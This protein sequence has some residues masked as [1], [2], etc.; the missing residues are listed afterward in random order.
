MLAAC[1]APTTAVAVP[2]T[3]APVRPQVVGLTPSTCRSAGTRFGASV[4]AA[5]AII[6][7]GLGGCSAAPPS[8]LAP[9]G[10][11]AARVAALFWAMAAGAVT[12]WAGV[13]GL[14]VYAARARPVSADVQPHRLIVIGGVLLPGVLLAALLAYGLRLMPAPAVAPGTLRVVV[15]GERWWWR[16]R[17]ERPGAAPVELANEL[18]LPAGVPVE[19]LLD[20]TDVIHSFWVPALGGKADMI[21]GQTTRLVLQPTREGVYRGVCA[22]YC[23]AAHAWMAFTT[24]VV[25]EA[26]FARWFAQQGAAAQAPAAGAAARGYERFLG[27]GCDG[28]H[29]IRGTPA[30]GR[31]GPD[32]THVGGRRT[33]GAGVLPAGADSLQRWI[34]HTA[35]VK[36]GVLMPSFAMLP[37]EDLRAIS[38]YLAGL[39]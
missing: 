39:Q 22:E 12:I 19:L 15:T 13:V 38:V 32:L 11:D 20:A 2:E 9:T 35:T 37:E 29:T 24:V 23:G 26:E 17:Y 31:V 14:A 5:A 1:K 36:P 10:A 4:A 6:L 30:R 33:L 18:R 25:S 28:C 16:V 3:H 21:P 8:L 7:V 34:A 27:N